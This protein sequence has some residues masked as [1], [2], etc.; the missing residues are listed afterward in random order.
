MQK[1]VSVFL[2]AWNTKHLTTEELLGSY[3]ADGWHVTSTTAAG[4]GADHQGIGV[5]VIFTLEKHDS[6]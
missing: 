4:G 1:I 5:W 3:F 6:P 2:Q